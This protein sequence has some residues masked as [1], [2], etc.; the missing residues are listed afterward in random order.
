MREV[1]EGICGNHSGSRSLVH[2]LVQARYY[3]STMQKDAKAYVKTYDKCQRFSNIIR[4]PTE[5]L[6][7]MM[8]LWPFA[9]WGL[10]IMGPFPIEVRQLKFQV[11][12][13]D[14]FTKWV[15]VEAL[16]TIIEKNVRSF[17]WRCIIC[18][19]GIPSVL[20]SDNGKQFDNDSFRDFCSLLGI[21]NHYSSPACPPTH[22]LMD[23]LKL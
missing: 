11:V 9:Q 12:G 13:I 5:E 4:Q 16:T 10:D 8:A 6:T 21:R 7:P 15:E 1:H 23:R 17:V 2:K 20:V 14:Y 19:F 18:R 3:W 22:K